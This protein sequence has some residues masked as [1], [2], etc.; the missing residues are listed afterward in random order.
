[1]TALS[2]TRVSVMDYH[3]WNKNHP[4]V[5]TLS[6]NGGMRGDPGFCKIEVLGW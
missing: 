3:I 4:F 6:L 2:D 5:A 1:M